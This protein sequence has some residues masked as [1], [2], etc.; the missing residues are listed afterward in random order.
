MAFQDFDLISERRKKE[1]QA[2]LRRRIIT[3]LVLV[4]VLLLAAA[5]AFAYFVVLKAPHEE[6]EKHASKTNKA[7]K[8]K[9][10]P[11]HPQPPPKSEPEAAVVGQ[12]EP[13]SSP[14][15]AAVVDQGE[16]PASPSKAAIV[17]PPSETPSVA[18]SEPPSQSPAEP[19][20]MIGKAEKVI[21]TICAGTD[22]NA[23][24]EDSLKRAVKE[25]A[26]AAHNPK[27]LLRS[28]M[29]IAVEEIDKAI[30]QA[31]GL[32][33]HTPHKKA[34]MDDCKVLLADA[35]E[36]LN[37]SMSGVGNSGLE[38]LASR[39]PDLNN[40]LSAVITFQDNCI[41]GF[42]DGEEK[43]AIRNSL[44]TA[45]EI[46]SNALAIVSQL[47]SALSTFQIPD[48]DL[49]RHLLADE[50]DREFPA[51][52]DHEERR[53]LKVEAPKQPPNATVAKDGSGNFTTINAA[54]AAI[55]QKYDGRYVIFVKEGIYEEN[56]V[57]TKKMV[58]LT[59][60]GVGSKKTIVTGSKNFVDGVSTY[61]TAT[62]AVMGDGFLGQSIGF[63]NTAGP[64]KHQA[65]AL[66]VQA[67]RA[68]FISCRMEAY[69]DTLYVQAHRQ[70]YRGCYITG[71]VDFIFGN[72]AAV[73]Q[74]C[75]IYARKPMENQQNIVT[76][77][78]RTDRRQTTGIVLQNCKIL[79]DD[80][81]EPEKAKTKSYLGRPWKEYSRTVVMESEIGDFIHP[82]GWMP[83]SGDFALET[84]YYAEYANSG[85]GASVKSRVNWGGY[86]G[87]IKKEEAME[88]TVGP[89]LQGDTWLKAAECPARFG[90][91]K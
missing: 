91:T 33:L 35:M 81:L 61:Q 2:K 68:I 72:A 11:P 63:R 4:V 73:F 70:F 30:K 29:A 53:I 15:K 28:S 89:F 19:P 64:E 66:R 54:L 34:A 3:A 65:V 58:N 37:S 27:E 80:T 26:S 67:D 1:K 46:A 49:K 9:Y 42:P 60:Y 78:G 90:L 16:P 43:T 31:G 25:N 14:S 57:V 38:S 62:F 17:E 75:M 82:E 71:T 7:H 5:A 74:N 8:P 84:L 50:D 59:I 79:A 76:A 88:Y 36:E 18:P 77:Q 52:M 13:P 86:K 48:L 23:T 22:Y 20:A 47:S 83:W 45:E 55:P 40:Y 51:W 12:G 41:D 69:Q 39:T 85:P 24:C 87:E 44:K 21:A 10:S 56:V 6:K 32:K